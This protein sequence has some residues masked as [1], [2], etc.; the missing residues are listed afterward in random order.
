MIRH[1][2][3][4]A[5]RYFIKD[6]VYSV[7]N[8]TGLALAVACSFL[9]VLWVQYENNYEHTHI[10]CKDIYRVLT[11][12]NM[13][14]EQVKRAT[15]PA[16]LGQVLVKEFPAITNATYLNVHRFPDVMVYNEQPYSAERAETNHQ[17]FEVFSYEFL[18][19]TP[20]TAFEGERPIV[21]SEEFAKKIFGATS[22]NIIGQPVYDRTRLWDNFKSEPPFIITA[23]VRLPKNTHIRFDVLVD[24]E[25][26]SHH[27]NASRTW[28]G[29]EHYT[30]F[31]QIAPNAAFNDATRTL[32]ANYLTNHLPDD[33]RM[34]V[35]QPLTGIHLNPEVTD[36]NLSGEFGDPRTIFIFLTM[37]IFVLAIAIINYV[38]LSIA[39]GAN[40]SRE[41][42]I[43]KVGGAYRREL[44]TQ[45]LIESMIWAFTAMIL[46]FLLAQIIIPWFSVVVG[47]ELHI[48]YSLRT[49]LTMF[50]L[51]LTVGLLAGSYSAF[52]LSS[53]RPV[54]SL[55]GG[56]LSGSKSTLRKTLLAVQLAISV[57]IILCTGVVYKQLYY[58][59]NKD[60]GFNRFHV[61]GINTGLWYDVGNFKEE[62]LKNA[63]V[64]AMSIA[65]YSP[66]DMNWGATL[67]WDGKTSDADGDCNLIWCDPD[68]AEVFRLQMAQGDFLGSHLGWR[69][70]TSEDS[71]AKV[72]NESAAKMIGNKDI[73]GK[74]VNGG[75]VVGVVKDFN[76]R[77]FHNKITPLIMEYNPEN[78]GKVF[79]RIS[80]E[81][82][83][84]TL[85][86]IRSVFQKF[87]KD[88]PFEYYFL[89]DEYKA[90]YQ[91]EFRLGR[92]F[93]YFSLL[94]IFISCMGVFSLVALMVKHRSKEVAIRKINGAEVID[95]VALF[96]R[97]FSALT[98]IAF[99]VASLFA[100]FAMHRWLQNYQ[101]HISISWWI[102][103]GAL[104]LILGLAM[105]SLIVQVY[106][107]KA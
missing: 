85:D 30:T 90:L 65:A 104:A 45:F 38:N 74:N 14:G 33:K 11:V 103:A 37:A 2:I 58:I 42:G 72:L 48:T 67:H 12:E 79:I 47:A 41:A 52:Y 60:I 100:W 66:F 95:I 20:Q 61:I 93:L 29:R 39:R 53:F 101:Y 22:G 21:L 18:Q 3:T 26:T 98:V 62:V 36:T 86:Y 64:E 83:K 92:V 44:I 7:I 35:F 51:S 80:P 81:N 70:Q 82:Q 25:K 19:G 34:L 63:H 27:G 102:F 75:K 16:P 94:S 24:A 10:H 78:A 6:K 5:F 84:A 107:A 40:R 50:G 46:A 106:R 57:F 69:H 87:K 23:V 28:N 77:S 55:K 59:Q 54:V 13:S 76:F 91:K 96:A 88:S 32:L 68:Y 4:I 89:K 49:F 9:F 97:E 105:L 15:T 17:F 56:S 8:L 31:V 99:V 73:I 1:Y 43:R 71:R